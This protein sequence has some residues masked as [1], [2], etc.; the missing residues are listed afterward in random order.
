MAIPADFSL[1]SDM[2]LCNPIALDRGYSSLANI[3]AA[4]NIGLTHTGCIT[5]TASPFTGD[6]TLESKW[7]VSENGYA[8]PYYS[9]YKLPDANNTEMVVCCFRQLCSLFHS[10]HTTPTLY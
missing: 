3:T 10:S 5:K 8:S 7:C 1:S 4:A 2:A 9:S 6:P